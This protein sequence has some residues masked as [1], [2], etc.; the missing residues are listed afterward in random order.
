MRGASVGRGASVV[1]MASVV[2]GAS[3]VMGAAVVFAAS[4]VVGGSY[5]VVVA[6]VVVVESCGSAVVDPVVCTFL[7]RYFRF[8]IATSPWSLTKIIGCCHQ[9]ILYINI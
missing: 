3:V 2:R 5:D 1:R 8:N 6:A 7:I 9:N 4:D